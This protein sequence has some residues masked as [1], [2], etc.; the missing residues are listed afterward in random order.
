[1]LVANM[2]TM[3]MRVFYKH[4]YVHFCSCHPFL[5]FFPACHYGSPTNPT[6]CFVLVYVDTHLH[7]RSYILAWAYFYGSHRLCTLLGHM[8]VDRGS[9]STT[10]MQCHSIPRKLFCTVACCCSAQFPLW[11]L[12][13]A[14][15][16]CCFMALPAWQ[17]GAGPFFVVLLVKANISS[18]VNP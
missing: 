15:Q 4:L 14:V 7:H 9:S 12:A 8:K 5:L 6:S 18:Q 2:R 1:M 13:A 11:K 16:S 3:V 10:C 17:G